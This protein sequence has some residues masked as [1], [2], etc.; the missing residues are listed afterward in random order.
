VVSVLLYVRAYVNAHAH[1]SRIPCVCRDS[2]MPWVARL[3][4]KGSNRKSRSQGVFRSLL[5]PV[6]GTPRGRLPTLCSPEIVR[7]SSCYRRNCQQWLRSPSSC[8]PMRAP[9]SFSLSRS[10]T[11]PLRESSIFLVTGTHNPHPR[12]LPAVGCQFVSSLLALF[13]TR[14]GKSAPLR[15]RW[16]SRYATSTESSTGA[17]VGVTR[18]SR[19][20]CSAGGQ[21]SFAHRYVPTER[22]YTNLIRCKLFFAS[23]YLL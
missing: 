16:I 6:S 23:N 7:R 2:F 18:G 19:R 9:S 14:R 3:D 20:R 12:V 11:H 22:V 17:Y 5:R 13:V 10:P 1:A 4:M 8:R 15:A 21:S